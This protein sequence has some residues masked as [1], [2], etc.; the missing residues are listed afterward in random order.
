MTTESKKIALL[1]GESVVMTSD[2]EVL[3]LTNF[4]VRYDAQDF[5]ASSLIGITLDALASC[6]LITRSYP[7][8]LILAGLALLVAFAGGGGN[9]ERQ[10]LL[11]LVTAVLVVAFFLTRRAVI[12]IA[13]NGG[14]AI[15]VPAKAMKR[16]EILKFIEAIEREKLMRK[17]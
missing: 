13:S 11:F 15:V 5:G 12:S 3:T 2:K 14:Q 6:G 9:S 8:L 7:V 16:A 10:Y 1:P 17:A 4:R